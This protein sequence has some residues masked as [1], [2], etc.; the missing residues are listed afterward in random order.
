MV[1]D[2]DRVEFSTL[3][4]SFGDVRVTDKE[5]FTAMFQLVDKA[6]LRKVVSEQKQ[7][8]TEQRE[9][10]KIKKLEQKLKEKLEKLQNNEQ[11]KTEKK[12]K[13]S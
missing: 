8:S 4:D 1:T 6:K 2:N 10:E 11:P 13:V 3:R 9:L 7:K 5:L 12:E